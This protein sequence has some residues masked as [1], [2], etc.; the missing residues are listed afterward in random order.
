MATTVTE[1]ENVTVLTIKDDLAGDAVEPFVEQASRC[2]EQG[3]HDLV[4]DCTSLGGVDSAGLEAFV[5]MQNKCED[6][7]GAVK[8]CGLDETTE[9]IL[10]ITRLARR[11]ETFEDVD[12]AVRSFA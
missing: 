10:E 12:T 7:L 9:K 5:D 11:F 1:Y 2:M 8:L 3:R 4:V 6:A